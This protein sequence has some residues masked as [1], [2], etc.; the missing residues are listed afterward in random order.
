MQ[1][2]K[3]VALAFL[4]GALVVGGGLGFTVDRA[5]LRQSICKEYNDR[6]SAR[7]RLADELQ[8]T[9][10]QRATLDSVLDRRHEQMST[11]V[12]QIRPQMDSVRDRTRQEIARML[13][14]QQRARFEALI[15]EAHEHD[16]KE[17]Q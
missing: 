14:P 2:S 4:L 3:S 5:L 8:L 12:R 17:R 15:R 1:R 13:N 16:Q 6:P 9:A 7:R 10:S 11:V